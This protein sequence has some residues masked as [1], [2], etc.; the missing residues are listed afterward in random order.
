[1]RR[2]S[3]SGFALV[4]LLVL[5]AL[6]LGAWWFRGDLWRLLGPERA[7]IE[8]SEE[9]AELALAKLQRLRD[10]GE[11]AHLSS[12]EVTSLVRFHGPVWLLERVDRPSVEFVGN[13]LRLT[14]TVSTSELPS[15]PELDRVRGLLPDSAQLEIVGS[16]RELPSGRFAFEVEGVSYASIPIPESYYPAVLQGFGRRDEPGLAPTAIALQLPEGAGS[17]RI[18]GGQLILTP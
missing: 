18:E 4:A 7:E 13:T 2:S 11:P 17:A 8:V 9:A 15:H 6:L 1:M 14:G 3:N 12:V 5:L 16:L 10:E